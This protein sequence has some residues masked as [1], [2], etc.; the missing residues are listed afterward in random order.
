MALSRAPSQVSAGGVS[1]RRFICSSSRK[2][3]KPFFLLW[4]TDADDRVGAYAV[5][6]DEELVEAS[7]GRQLACDGGLGILLL[8]QDDQ[9]APHGVD[10]DRSQKL[11][12][13]DFWMSRYGRGCSGV[14]RAESVVMTVHFSP[15]LAAS[16]E[17][18][19]E[20][21]QVNAIA[22]GR[23]RMKRFSNW[24]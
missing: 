8:V 14:V 9:I 21:Q 7:Q 15:G 24:R 20:L 18:F 2:L 12:N 16:G 23:M 19:T 10:I 4:R 5:S 11:V 22:F 1:R 3:R 6:F 13:I 17:E